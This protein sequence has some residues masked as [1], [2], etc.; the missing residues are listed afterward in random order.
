[1]T[2]E[3]QTQIQDQA[4]EKSTPQPRGQILKTSIYSR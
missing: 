4:K 2:S 1:M 3:N